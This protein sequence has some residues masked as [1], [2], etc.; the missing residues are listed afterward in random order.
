MTAKIL[1]VD[2]EK[3]LERLINQKFRKNIRGQ[4]FEF[5]YAS[6]G[7]EALKKLQEEAP[8]DMVLSD[9][10]M[11]GLDGLSLLTK[12]NE[13]DPTIKTVIM[14]AYG[15]MEKIRTAMNRGAFDFLTKP[16]DF[17]DLEIT[18]KRTLE[19]V[20]E[21]KENQ[22]YRQEKEE[23]LQRSEKYAKE[24]AEQLQKALQELQNTQA[25][26]VQTE[27]M[28]SLGQLVAGVA[29]EINN[30]VNF[31]FGN[32]SHAND[33]TQN[34]L[35]L[36]QLYAQHYPNPV[37]E[38]QAEIE[39]TDL[40]F[41]IE[42]LP[43]L[44]GSMKLGADRIRDIVRSLRTFSRV[45]ESAMKPVDIHEGIDST[46]LILHNRLKAK[47]DQPGIR[48]IKQYGNLPLVEC[49]AGQ[50]N[51]VFMNLITNAIDALE[52]GN[53]T[54]PI[55]REGGA[56]G[57]YLGGYENKEQSRWLQTECPVAL[58]L[59]SNPTIWIRTEV[60]NPDWVEIRIADNG[61][62]M[63][64]E[65]RSRLFDTFFTT[66]PV[67][68][69]TGLGLSISHQ[70][71]IEKHGGKLNCISAIGEGAEFIIQIPMR[72]SIYQQALLQPVG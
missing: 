31:I 69:G 54:P 1:V 59:C 52:M 7:V 48:V 10:N 67:G 51:Q 21:L 66:K 39:A 61:P 2:D 68:K 14:S 56:D 19:H 49:Y 71:V 4:Y 29:H 11:P 22:R 28:S 63:S 50:L 27:K 53:E 18:I 32:L 30:P 46:L 45:D 3:D 33:Y 70:I 44:L 41:L 42:D 36:L 23:S 6:N 8:I 26:L 58:T 12:I 25:K 5:V 38:I 43:R 60:I 15:D 16:L 13:F 24:Q 17:Q 34:L 47:S 72:Q 35:N 37:P 20:K 62:G 57:Y 65:V 9:I 64:Q 40:E 55:S